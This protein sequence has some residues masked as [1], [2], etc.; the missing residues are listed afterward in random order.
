MLHVTGRVSERVRG[1]V[2]VCALLLLLVLRSFAKPT[3]ASTLNLLE[4]LVLKCGSLHALKVAQLAGNP[5]AF[6]A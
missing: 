3:I 4:L 2:S 1:F 5:T 6:P